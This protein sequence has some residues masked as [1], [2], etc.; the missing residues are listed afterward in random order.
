[1]GLAAGP[2]G[3]GAASATKNPLSNPVASG[4]RGS[5][6]VPE[7][8]DDFDFGDMNVSNRACAF[9]LET[10]FLTFFLLFP[11]SFFLLFS[12]SPRFGPPVPRFQILMCRV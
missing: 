7:K 3:A 4:G 11:L 6:P 10:Y 5:S 9:S 8:N 1:M 2:G 12:L